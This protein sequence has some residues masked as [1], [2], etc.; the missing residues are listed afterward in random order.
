MYKN[1]L[2]A[3]YQLYSWVATN[4]YAYDILQYIQNAL[5]ITDFC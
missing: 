2:Y 3:M 1:Y 4:V 5:W